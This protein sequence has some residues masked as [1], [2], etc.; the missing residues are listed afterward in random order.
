MNIS[1]YLSPFVVLAFALSSCNKE[2]SGPTPASENHLKYFGFT[3]VDVGWDDP[4]E[5]AIKTSYV[6][7]V[8]AF[9]NVADLLAVS[10]T[11]NLVAKIQNLSSH[12]MKAIIHLNEIFFEPVGVGGPSG[13]LFDLRTDYQSRW[14]IFVKTNDLTVNY[15]LVQAFYVGEEPT[16][17]S[18][19]YLELKTATDYIKTSIPQVP[20]LLIEGYPSL[21]AL[22]VPNSVDWIG[23][24]HYFIKDPQN[25]RTFLDE[26][27]QLKSKRS[28]QTQK[29]VLVLDAHFISW[30]HLDE[31]GIAES[32]MKDV[33]TS[34][35]NLAQ[36]DGDVIGLLGY[37]W[38]GGFDSPEAK[39][40]RQLPQNARDEYIRIGRLI[41]GK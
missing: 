31:G 24:D 29:I 36:S 32:E 19:S 4:L 3:L 15:H 33:A 37:A 1:D 27:S 23:F 11:D 2:D 26:L 38:P 34:Y 7:E 12:Q 5:K 18:I 20:I 16:W 25:N 14:D 28:S 22:Q 41:S 8:A 39:G 9:S 21:S 30:L 35:Y 40:A 10:P 13:A 17:N 6:D